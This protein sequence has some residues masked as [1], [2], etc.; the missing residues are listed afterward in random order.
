MQILWL[1]LAE[2]DLVEL[3]DYLLERNPR[4]AQRVYDL[5]RE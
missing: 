2:A 3:F 5:I 4:A 1:D